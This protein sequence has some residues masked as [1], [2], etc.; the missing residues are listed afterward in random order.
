MSLSVQDLYRV[1]LEFQEY[2]DDLF[3]V[4]KEFLHK[5]MIVKL[6]TI[7]RC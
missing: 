4:M 6:G 7:E 1:Q 2:F 5:L 3:D